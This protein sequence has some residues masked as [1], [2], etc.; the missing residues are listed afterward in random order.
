[1]ARGTIH[2]MKY[3]IGDIVIINSPEYKVKNCQA[4]IVNMRYERVTTVRPIDGTIFHHDTFR[5]KQC[6][7]VIDHDTIEPVTTQKQYLP[8]ELFHV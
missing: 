8:E 3:K 7:H 4:E 6:H 2:I 1:M 5:R